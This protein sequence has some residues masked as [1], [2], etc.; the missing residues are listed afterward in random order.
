MPKRRQAALFAVQGL[1]GFDATRSLPNYLYRHVKNR[2]LNHVRNHWQRSDTPC[3]KCHSGCPCAD[4]IVC[5]KYKLWKE[6]QTRKRSTRRFV[7]LE[8]FNDEHEPRAKIKASAETDAETNEILRLIDEHLPVDLRAF[9]LQMRVGV[10][11]ST[12][13]RKQ[14]E[15]EILRIL[16]DNGLELELPWRRKDLENGSVE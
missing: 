15:D 13:F 11:V 5:L 6:R 7:P 2:M 10:Q 8:K 16:S 12:D 1:K 9:W 3:A 14:V 4:G